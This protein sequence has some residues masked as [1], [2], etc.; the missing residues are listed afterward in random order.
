MTFNLMV[1]TDQP[2]CDFVHAHTIVRLAEN[3]KPP[4]YPVE[5]KHSNETSVYKTNKRT[6]P[7]HILHAGLI[8]NGHVPTKT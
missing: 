8:P 1:A 4:G 3:L 7:R 5:N 2:V 6:L